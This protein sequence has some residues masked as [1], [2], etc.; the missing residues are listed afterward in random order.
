[1]RRVLLALLLAAALPAALA[2]QMGPGGRRMGNRGLED[3]PADTTPS[4]ATRGWYAGVTTFSGGTWQPSG[5]DVGMVWRTPGLPFSTLGLGLRAGS[6]IQN[7]AVLIGSTKGFFIGL[8]GSARLPIATLMMVGSE[9]NPAY[10]RLEGL[11]DVVGSWNIDSP[12]AQ[13]KFSVLGAPLA[14]ITVGGRGPM[15]QTVMILVGPAWFG[16]TGSEW[17]MQVGLRFAMP[18]RLPR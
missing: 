7:Q 3:E 10:V 9:R 11:L 2:A 17:Q 14:A 13:G 5:L 15:D 16:P 8:V 4:N 18:A 1:M 12:M 6:F